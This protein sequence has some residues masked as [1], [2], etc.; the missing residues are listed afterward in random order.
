LKKI[1]SLTV[2]A[3]SDL[4]HLQTWL[5]IKMTCTI[6]HITGVIYMNSFKY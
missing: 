1:G 6:F 3:G 2:S 4:T 5:T